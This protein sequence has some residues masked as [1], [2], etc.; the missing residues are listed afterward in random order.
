MGFAG[1]LLVLAAA[2]AHAGWNFFAKQAGAAGAAF[3]WLTAATSSVVYL[4]VMALSLLWTGLPALRAAL[5]GAVVSATLHLGYFLLLQRGYAVGDMSVVYPLARGTGPLLAMAIAV[6]ILGERP[7]MWGV[8]GGLLVIAGVFVISYSG[9]VSGAPAAQWAGIG[10]GV[11]TGLLIALYTVWDAHAVTALALPP[12]LYDWMNNTTRAV[13]FAPYAL[14]RRTRVAEIW[15]GHRREVTAVAVLSPLAYILVLFAM[16]LAPVS[17][18]APARELSIVLAS[19]LAWRLL[20]EPQPVRRLAGAA[21]VLA[22]V[23][24]HGMA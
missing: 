23:V 20:R 17:L 3:V 18:V 21:V 24:V 15:S 9:G 19:L 8:F 16:Q 2:C 12:L 4:P 5:L 10:F 6:V 14:R 1:L 11:L 22:G 13:M 7:G